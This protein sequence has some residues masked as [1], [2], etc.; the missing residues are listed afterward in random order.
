M[1]QKRGGIV[2]G[3]A[4]QNKLICLKKKGYVSIFNLF[5][6]IHNK[7]TIHFCVLLNMP[8]IHILSDHMSPPAEILPMTK[9]LLCFPPLSLSLKSACSI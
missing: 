8:I 9:A 3:A 4:Q 6:G 1:T 7:L 2:S 5:F